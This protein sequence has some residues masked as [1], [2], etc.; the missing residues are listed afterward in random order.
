MILIQF[1]F[2]DRSQVLMNDE[3][4]D[5]KLINEN[6]KDYVDLIWREKKKVSIFFD[7]LP[8]SF[9]NFVMVIEKKLKKNIVL[10][11]LNKI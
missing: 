6:D 4:E 1:L 7:N 2:C 9:S 10:T 8:K 11:R 5:F 3:V